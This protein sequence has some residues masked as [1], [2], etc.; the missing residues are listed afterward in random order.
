MPELLDAVDPRAEFVIDE[1]SLPS[2]VP[3]PKKAAQTIARLRARQETWIHIVRP[4]EIE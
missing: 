2:V 3:Q 4:P 1:P